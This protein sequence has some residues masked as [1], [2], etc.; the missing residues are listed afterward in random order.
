[1]KLCFDSAP[2]KKEQHRFVCRRAGAT[3]R[4][5]WA[6]GGQ[7]SGVAPAR[8]SAFSTVTFPRIWGPYFFAAEQIAFT[9]GEETGEDEGAGSNSYLLHLFHSAFRLR[10]T[11]F[12]PWP[13]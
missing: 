3:P 9:Q 2:W 10:N 5:F 8:F 4:T 12:C 6:A 13:K 11:V 1:M 7:K